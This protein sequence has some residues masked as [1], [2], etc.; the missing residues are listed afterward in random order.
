MFCWILPTAEGSIKKTSWLLLD[1]R[2]KVVKVPAVRSHHGRIYLRIFFFLFLSEFC[3]P[4]CRWL[5]VIYEPRTI[6]H[7]ERVDSIRVIRFHSLCC[8]FV[9]V[10]VFHAVVEAAASCNPLRESFTYS[11]YV[12]L[13]RSLT[14]RVCSS[15]E[16][17]DPLTSFYHPF[18]FICLPNETDVDCFR[19]EPPPL[20]M[21]VWWMFPYRLAFRTSLV[22]ATR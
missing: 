3:K 5:D 2:Q 18:W 11:F 16:V 9:L 13:Q 17:R 1:S 4:P 6:F 21:W 19:R 22:F 10:V 8:V 20:T 12:G 15:V 14:K 7:R